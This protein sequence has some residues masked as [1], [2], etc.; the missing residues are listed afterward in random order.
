MWSVATT[1]YELYTGRI[2]FP[3]KSNNQM[4]KFFF[5][6]KGKANSKMIRK[7]T[8]R[9]LHF[10]S[11]NNFLYQEVDK[12]TEREKVVVISNFK[13]RDLGAEV[14]AG[15]SLPED[16]LRKVNQLKDMLEKALSL[17]PSK[18]LTPSGALG[19]PFIAEKI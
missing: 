11:N 4:L 8:F 10:D 2:M 14:M 12:V 6:L 1:L 9:D 15:Q 18:R 3:G 16:Q 7:A 13:L 5:D 19:H 17:D